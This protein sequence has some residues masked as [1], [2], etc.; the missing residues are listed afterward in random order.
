MAVRALVSDIFGEAVEATVTEA[1]RSTVEA[2]QA[3]LDEGNEHARGT[4]V[5]SRL[6]V[7]KSAGYDRIHRALGLG[8]IVN[9]AGRGERGMRLKLGAPLPADGDFLPR[10]EEIVRH[11]SGS[12]SGLANPHDIEESVLL[13]G[14]PASPADPPDGGDVDE[15]EVERLAALAREALAE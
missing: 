11:E 15:D 6:G 10:A 2:V 1:T 13:S 8:Y 5:L 3:I 4:D 14:S 7:G 9:D 12:P